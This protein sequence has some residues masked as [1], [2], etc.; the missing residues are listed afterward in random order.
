MFLRALVSRHR[1]RKS[2]SNKT[3]AG[4]NGGQT[5]QNS[6]HKSQHRT[7]LKH[8]HKPAVLI[9]HSLKYKNTVSQKTFYRDTKLQMSSKISKGERKPGW[10]KEEE[11][12]RQCRHAH[13]RGELKTN[14]WTDKPRP[15][16]RRWVFGPPEFSHLPVAGSPYWIAST[17]HQT[18]GRE[19]NFPS[20][21]AGC[22]PARPLAS[23]LHRLECPVCSPVYRKLSSCQIPSCFPAG[24]RTYTG[25]SCPAWA[26]V[27]LFIFPLCPA[28]ILFSRSRDP[29]WAPK[30]YA[31]CPNP[32]VGREKAS[33]TTRKKGSLLLT[34]ARAPAASNAVVQGQRALSPSCYTKFIG[35]A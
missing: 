34:Q 16:T 23:A 30:C 6:R 5:K 35:L 29:G 24:P 26:P 11:D 17:V 3:A 25:L 20:S 4:L 19:R 8:T 31:R 18:R 28:S 7:E 1:E 22:L 12:Q 9:R 13:K 33:K 27:L 15:I 21:R 14:T 32:R 2:S 10:K